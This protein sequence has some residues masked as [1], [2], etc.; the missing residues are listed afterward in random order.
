MRRSIPQ[1]LLPTVAFRSAE[2]RDPTPGI[3]DL[4]EVHSKRSL[5]ECD[6][7]RHQGFRATAGG[8]RRRVS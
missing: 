3:D 5:S 7:Y 2:R 4:G 6:P 1:H 8:T